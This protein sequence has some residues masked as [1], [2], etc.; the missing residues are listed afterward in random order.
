M[1]NYEYTELLKNLNFKMDNITGVVE[2]QKIQTRLDAI[3][4]LENEQDFWLDASYAAK[5]QK[6]KTQ[7]QRKLDKYFLA[8]DAIVDASE[9]YDMAK[10]ENDEESIEACYDDA[11]ELEQHIL[12]MEIEVLL[13]GE[14]DAN[15]SGLPGYFMAIKSKSPTPSNATKHS[16]LAVSW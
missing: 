12:N 8:K 15:N 3:K 2:P 16:L 4:S 7:L 1:D 9:L 5:V 11:S 6:E 14:S 13:S 10:E